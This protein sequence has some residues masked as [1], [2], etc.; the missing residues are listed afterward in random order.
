[1]VRELSL[2]SKFEIFIKESLN[3]K[4]RKLNGERI[5]PQ[6]VAN[7][8]QVLLLLSSYEHF[9]G[10]TLI[11]KINM[12][13]NRRLIEK[14]RKN[15]KTFYR[16][17]SD[18]LF[19]QK[20]CFDNYVGSVFKNIK[21]FFRYLR[22]EKGLA[23]HEFYE[24]FYVRKEEIRIITLLPE[25]FCYLITDKNFE[26]KLS[27]RLRKWKD[28]FVFGC[29]V[30]LRFSDLTNL[31]VRDIERHNNNYFLYYRSLKQILPPQ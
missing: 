19:E 24:G 27:S 10:K 29:T 26:N 28:M 11:I 22:N 20:N 31:Q 18:Y 3:G 13:N 5:K 1:M 9:T 21:C 25:R 30:A 4:R 14:E 2:I 15:W 16:H 7:Y 17:F 8:R 12:G 23:L 6:T